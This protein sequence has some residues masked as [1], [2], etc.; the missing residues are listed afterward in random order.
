MKKWLLYNLLVGFA[1]YWISNL[2]LWFPWTYSVTLGMT[3]MLTVSP[4]L[5]AGAS[6]LCL[7]SYP[8]ERLLSA[9][10]WNAGILLLLAIVLDYLF[11]GLVRDAFEDLYHPTTFYG[12]GFVLS[13][14]FLLIWLLGRKI[15]ARKRALSRTDFVRAGAIA[16]LAVAIMVLI[17]LLEG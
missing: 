1:V 3:L 15:R 6:F 8:G 7:R 11:F 10:A 5:W 9:A 12:Y 4:L 2:V 17:L 14:P 13:L 16:G